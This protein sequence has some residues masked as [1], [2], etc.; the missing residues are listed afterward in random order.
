MPPSEDK[1]LGGGLIGW[2]IQNPVAANL[3]MVVLLIGGILF[4]GNLQTQ[5][6]PTIQPG[7][8]NVTV[9]YP[10]A[11]P[12]E[13]E[14]GVTR[15]V[16]EAVL[17][18][19]GVKRVSS[20]ASENVGTVTI[21]LAD[22]A[23]KQVVKDDVQTAVESLADFPPETAERE[24]ISAPK[25]TGS[26]VTLVVVGSVTPLELRQAAENLER[27]L[28]TQN[29]ISLVSLSGDRDYE[30]SIEV[31]E[32]TLQEFGLS[33]DD[34][35]RAVR[36]GSL[37]LAGG[38]IRTQSGEYL[39]RTNQRRLTGDEFESIVESV[40]SSRHATSYCFRNDEQ[41]NKILLTK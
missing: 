2:F 27:E 11:T 9:P 7:I 10:G 31:S 24:T 5:V 12:A 36:A 6:F 22:F 18:I 21:E 20:T 35:A 34:V 30:I 13:V 25:P 3:L 38:S 33:I 14:E 28:L 19:D 40:C 15:R 41:D 32:D 29:G 26:V 39:L 37:D 17:G 4:A 8:V 16:E 1:K 23:D